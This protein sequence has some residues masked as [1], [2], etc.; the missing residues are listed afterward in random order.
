MEHQ[1]L[2]KP[3]E[4]P[5]TPTPN[6]T[7]RWLIAVLIIFGLAFSGLG[8]AQ[9]EANQ[10]LSAQFEEA[11]RSMKNLELRTA[12]LEMDNSDLKSDL[13]AA[14]EKL[15]LTEKQLSQA[16]AH[17]RKLQEAQQQAAAELADHETLLGS[18]TNDVDVVKDDVAE[19]RETLESTRTELA[20][21]VG[22]LGIQSGLIARNQDELTHLKRQGARNYYDLNVP[23]SKSYARVGEI[24]VRLN[25][26]DVKRNKYTVTLLVNDRQIEKK[27]K[28]LFEP[29]QFYLPGTRQLLEIVVFEI[30]KDRVTGY[31]SA[32][33]ELA[34]ARQPG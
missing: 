3:E 1:D 7:P 24:S 33:R 34:S 16:R 2:L 29:V 20:R 26:V 6:G 14:T 11:N 32:P 23:K 12:S 10:S 31:L 15:G 19:T 4:T 21:A 8:Y 27:D 18:I 25:K 13:R 17:A 5:A 9:Y 30:G 28:T 22:D